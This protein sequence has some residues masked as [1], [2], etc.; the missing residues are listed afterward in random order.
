MFDGVTSS[1]TT[2]HVGI[3]RYEVDQCLSNLMLSEIIYPIVS[4]P[5]LMFLTALAGLHCKAQPH[6]L[7][8]TFSV[9]VSSFL[10]A[11]FVFLGL[12]QELQLSAQRQG[13][14]LGSIFFTVDRSTALEPMGRDAGAGSSSEPELVQIP[15][16]LKSLC[17]KKAPKTK[18]KPTEEGAVDCVINQG[19]RNR[20]MR[21]LL[22][23][24]T[25]AGTRPCSEKVPQAGVLVAARGSPGCMGE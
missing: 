17:S 24:R 18:T 16:R 12:V 15:C 20:H 22:L 8:S 6:P 7:S 4:A 14:P 3:N 11:S 25:L 19:K 1:C 13:I 10:S 21:V 9:E 23:T 2:P 5:G